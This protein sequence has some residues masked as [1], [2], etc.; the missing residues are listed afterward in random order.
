M[1]RTLHLLTFSLAALFAL[2]VAQ[3]AQAQDATP[4]LEVF[5]GYSYMHANIVVNGTPFNLN[6]ASGSVAYNVNYWLGVAGDFG[7]YHQGSVI[8]N[9]FS[10]TLSSYQFGPRFSFRGHKLVPYGQ[11]LLGAGHATGTLYTTSL[12]TGLAPLGA[13]N[14]FLLTA[15]GGVDWK[16]NHTIGIRIVQAEYLYSQ[17]LN[18]AGNNN[19]QNNLRISTGIVFSFGKR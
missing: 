16:V 13:N 15:G 8:G 18:G 14:G 5:G 11:V 19:R 9:G 3:A 2:G 12:G 1:R 7:V 6:G 10:L 4:K 17:F